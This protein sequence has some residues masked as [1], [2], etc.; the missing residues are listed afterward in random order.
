[1]SKRSIDEV[2]GTETD[3]KVRESI[4]VQVNIKHLTTSRTGL[5]SIVPL[6]TSLRTDLVS[7]TKVLSVSLIAD[8]VILTHPNTSW[9]IVAL[10]FRMMLFVPIAHC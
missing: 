10:V 3:K 7:S 2:N 4:A 8:V 6:N 5:W 9:L 1:M